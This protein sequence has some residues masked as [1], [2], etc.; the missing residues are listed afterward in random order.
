MLSFTLTLSRKP[1]P[2]ALERILVDYPVFHDQLEVCCRVDH[3]FHVVQWVTVD[4]DDVGV[5]TFFYHSKCAFG[6]WMAQTAELQKLSVERR[7][8][9]KN[10]DIREIA[11]PRPE[12]QRLQS[13][14][15]QGSEKIR[16][17][18]NF[19]TQLACQF[20]HDIRIGIDLS[21]LRLGRCSDNVEFFRRHSEEVSL[22]R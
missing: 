4:D 1:R 22:R 12:L 19:H 11:R 21:H 3:E 16:A 20:H 10:V 18:S 2:E 15:V 6:V 7:R 13:L 5:G 17:P 9:A 14:L 8:L